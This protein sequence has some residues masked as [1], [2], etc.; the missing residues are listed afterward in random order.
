VI[1]PELEHEARFEGLDV[2]T[3]VNLDGPKGMLIAAEKRSVVLKS[4]DDPVCQAIIDPKSDHPPVLA[5]G[6]RRS[7]RTAA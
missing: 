5:F 4:P 7:A 6:Y 2:G 1:S 3:A